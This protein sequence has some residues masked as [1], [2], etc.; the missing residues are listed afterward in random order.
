MDNSHYLVPIPYGKP[1]GM[2]RP[3]PKISH[4]SRYY[5]RAELHSGDSLNKE[6]PRKPSWKHDFT[7][8]FTQW[9][10]WGRESHGNL[11]NTIVGLKDSLWHDI[12]CYLIVGIVLISISFNQI[13]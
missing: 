13:V 6:N 9:R 1:S 3:N 5:V 8:Y 11:S 12:I 2:W 4:D 10:Y 7:R